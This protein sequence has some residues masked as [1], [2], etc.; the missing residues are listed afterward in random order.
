MNDSK[1]KKW[2][3]LRDKVLGEEPR[4]GCR[5]CR[6]ADERIAA[7]EW[8]GSILVREVEVYLRSVS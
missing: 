6:E 1:G 8:V 7:E 4:G 5:W 3:D 2:L